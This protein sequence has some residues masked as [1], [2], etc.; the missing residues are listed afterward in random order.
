MSFQDIEAAGFIP[1]KGELLDS[2]QDPSQAV[3]A[4]IFQINTSVSSFKRLI[5]SLG[6]AKDT[7]ELRDKIHKT[8]QHIGRLA[9]E[10]AS[11]L[12]A[13]SETDHRSPAVSTTKKVGD[14][15][16]A[17]DF[18]A[19]LKEFQKAQRTAAERETAYSPFVR[20]IVAPKSR[21]ASGGNGFFVFHS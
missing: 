4:G 21:Y 20:E 6:T 19:V 15:K 9:K 16:L 10:T 5:N 8:R 14:A 7:P 13:A 1:R 18:E 12:K 3:A 17:K 2:K 11:K